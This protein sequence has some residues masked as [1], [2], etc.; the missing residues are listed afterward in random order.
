MFDGRWRT[1]VDRA[2]APIGSALRRTGVTAD[3]LTVAGLVMAV[4]SAVAI[5]TGRIG[6]GLGLLIASAVPDLLDGPVA[7]AAGTAGPRGAFFD[8]VADRIADA[9]ILGGI[10]WYLASDRGGHVVLLPFAALA[11]ASLVSYQRAKA[12]SLGYPARG[13]LMERAERI[14][15]LCAG[16]A[17]PG[18]LVPMLWVVLVLS[19]VTAI[20]R[21]VKVW[22]LASVERPPP[23]RR[24]RPRIE[25]RW[26]TWRETA[27]H[28]GGRN[29]RREAWRAR[30][31]DGAGRRRTSTRP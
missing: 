6:L 8:S 14:V 21:F 30:R 23:D 20:Q 19:S 28:H 5:A 25:A 16:L 26:R 7:K 13:G 24:G 3:Q 22:Q 2:T 10:G 4:A 29:R 12:E 31:Q 11:V 15:A 9:L 18:F 17:F 27:G 1:G